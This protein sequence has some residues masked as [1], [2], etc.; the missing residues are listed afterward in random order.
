M[1][2]AGEIQ[3]LIDRQAILD[4]LT[5]YGRGVDRFDRELVL[6]AY[7]PDAID[8][9]GAFVGTREEFIRSSARRPW[10]SQAGERKRR[11]L[12]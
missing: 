6:S 9:H 11:S 2:F 1:S 3:H 5:R 8:D 12:H 4:C 10:P 7:H